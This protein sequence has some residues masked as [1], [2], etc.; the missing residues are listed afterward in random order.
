MAQPYGTEQNLAD[1][2]GTDLKTA[3]STLSGSTAS[4]IY[5]RARKFADTEI[6]MALGNQWDITSFSSS[7]ESI[8]ML[9]DL[10]TAYHLFARRHVAGQDAQAYR[11]QADLLLARIQSGEYDLDGA[12]RVA[13]TNANVGMSYAVDDTGPA[14][15]GYDPDT[16]ADRSGDW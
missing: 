8:N 11:D 1:T 7:I 3:V 2:I 6:D 9:S 13:A 16:E 5:T 15:S 10:L 4:E 12:T 14:F